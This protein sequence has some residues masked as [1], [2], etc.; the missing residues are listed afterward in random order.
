M[1]ILV[2]GG[3]GF[4]G[5]H[6]VD[7]LVELQH[8]VIVVDD[9]SANNEQFYYN[10]K[11]T[12]HKFSICDGKQLKEVSKKCEFC[13][14][15]AAESRLQNAIKN[16]TRAVD[17]NVGGTLNVLEACKENNIEGLVFSSTSSIYG[18]TETLPTTEDERDNCLNPYASTKYCGELLLKN[19]NS[20]YGV[21]SCILRYFN[22]FG[23]RAPTKGQ[24]ALVTGIFF[25][26]KSNNEPLTIVGDGL[27]TRDF[28]YV[29]DV[30]SANITCMHLW[31]SK[32]SLHKADV[33]NI[34]YGDSVKIKDLA[35]AID[36][37]VVH[38]PERK[39]EAK[40]TLSSYKKFCKIT[41]WAPS[42]HILDWVKSQ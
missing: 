14:H 11:A 36:S 27:Q 35:L 15:L 38:I 7:A 5:S 6:L 25:R 41:G 1:K 9:C 42:V 3:C 22:V 16:P 23:E 13:F 32:H 8:D 30:V 28:I 29:K 12:Y 31:K 40:N 39:G 26:Q 34:G 18:L 24:Y 33:F 21:K 17:V 19:Y 4:I 2:T 10:D 20:L 37:N